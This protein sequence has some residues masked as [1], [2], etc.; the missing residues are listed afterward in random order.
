MHILV[1]NGPN[2]NLLGTREKEIYGEA[3][4]EDLERLLKDEAKRLKVRIDVFQTN[5][6]GTIIDKIHEAFHRRYS[7]IILNPGAYTHY[8]YAIRDAIKGVDLPVVEVHLSDL[9]KREEFRKVSVIRD[10]CAATFMGKGF[11]S[12]LEALRF[13]AVGH[14]DK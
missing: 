10:V 14:A 4:L 2:L 7:G 13:L 12:Y 6:E 1:I 8:S 3:T 11:Q 5:H 9:T